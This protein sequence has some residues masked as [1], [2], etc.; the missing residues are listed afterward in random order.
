[1][2]LR[3]PLILDGATGTELQK[4]GYCGEGCPESWIL[5]QPQALLSIQR[6]YVEAGSQVIYAPTFGAN[7]AKL[8]S[9]GLYGKVEEYNL[10]LAAL[11]R[12]AAGGRAWVAG[13]LAPTGLFL[14]PFGDVSFRELTEI[15]AQQVSALEKAGVD[16]YV[17]ETMVSLPE[18]RAALLAVKSL[19]RKPVFVS[20]SC[21]A[22]GRTMTGTDVAAALKVMEGM[23]ADAF[24]LNC[25][26]GPGDMLP[27]LRRLRALSRLPLIAKPNAGLPE[28]VEG[29][30]VYNCPP[31][32]F[33][34]WA[35]PMAETG[36]MIFGGCC[37]AGAEHISALVKAVSGREMRY[38]APE[39]E[40]L[41][42]CATEKE[43]FL[44]P[45]ETEPGSALPCSPELEELLEDQEGPV[46]AIRINSLQE[47][48]D[49]SD[50]QHLISKPLC[51]LCEDETVLEEALARYQGRAMYQGSLSR[52]RLLPLCRKYGL[53]V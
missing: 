48:E 49:F 41:L 43:L 17:I 10:A 12:E 39:S 11:S 50:W 24:G 9:H 16:L 36:V 4:Q 19:S 51:L 7:R 3:F 27:Q 42:P 28:L 52:E 15:Y 21:G 1:M 34:A 53:I 35:G 47:L 31:A 14:Y 25:S 45:P 40:A 13:D 30:T 38:P 26:A 18:A 46:T 2:E 33:A 23:G 6:A 5:E 8:E 32:E 29:K 44:L 22:D 20:F 37:G